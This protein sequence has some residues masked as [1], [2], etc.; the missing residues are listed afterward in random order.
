MIH[1]TAAHDKIQEL[2][3][4]NARLREQEEEMKKKVG[5]L[6]EEVKKRSNASAGRLMRRQTLLVADS[7]RRAMSLGKIEEKIG[8]Q[9]CVIPGYNSGEWPKSKYPEKSQKI[10]VEN[11]M[12][13]GTTDLILQL[14]C[15][16]ISNLDHL[17]NDVKLSFAMAEK[18]TRNTVA[19]AVTA[20]KTNQNL[21][22]VLILMRSPRLDCL[23]LRGL[24]EHANTILF[25]EVAKSGFGKQI[26]IGTM[27]KI[28]IQTNDQIHQVFGSRFSPKTD[29]IHMRGHRGQEMYTSAIIEAIENTLV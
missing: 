20:L 21:K 11:N 9:L 4:D 27:D 29:F 2:E 1:M 16:D 24:S 17:K 13:P 22:N 15:N 6:E 26:K 25:N 28:L 8:G 12:K 7:H 18:S 23:K 5:E 10:V 19:I 14:S 3:E